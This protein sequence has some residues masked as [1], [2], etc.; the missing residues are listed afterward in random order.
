MIRYL[1]RRHMDG[2]SRE[3]CWLQVKRCR[4]MRVRPGPD[5]LLPAHTPTKRQTNSRSRMNHYRGGF[6]ASSRSPSPAPA[7]PRY[8][9]RCRCRVVDGQRC[10]AFAFC[11]NAVVEWPNQSLVVGGF[12]PT[13]GML[14]PLSCPCCSPSRGPHSFQPPHL[15]SLPSSNKHKHKHFTRTDI[16]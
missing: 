13:R 4:W 9:C 14:L 8:R 11:S 2:H 16:N 1:I 3:T 7:S 5:G 10:P 12:L 15:R 6:S